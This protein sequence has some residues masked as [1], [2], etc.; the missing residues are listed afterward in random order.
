MVLDCLDE[1]FKKATTS[2]S[3]AN[4]NANANTKMG[5]I[6][7]HNKPVGRRGRW[8]PPRRKIHPHT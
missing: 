3:I 4:A 2:N 1:A 7:T 8:T 5:W 6:L